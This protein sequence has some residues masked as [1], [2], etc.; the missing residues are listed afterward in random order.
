V[1][2][3]KRPPRVKTRHADRPSAGNLARSRLTLVGA[4]LMSAV[5]LVAWFPARALVNQRSSLS[6]ATNQLYRMHQEDVALSQEKKN[7]SDLTE[8]ARIAREE[9]QL[10]SPGQQAFEVLPPSGAATGGTSYAG[11]PG[12]NP[13]VAPSAASE[14]PPG[15][16]STMTTPT[17]GLSRHLSA[18]TSQGTGNSGGVLQRMLHA[19]EFWR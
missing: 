12:S 8:I 7:L 14:L 16:V 2:Q 9:Y 1:V 6:G 3:A 10:V 19:L 15:G 17:S 5:I 4:V 18:P 11:D 13:P